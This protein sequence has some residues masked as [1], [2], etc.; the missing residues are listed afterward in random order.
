MNQKPSLYKEMNQPS[1]FNNMSNFLK[2]FN[3]FRSTFTGDPKAQVQQLI[4]SGQL[5]QEQF[6]QFA[7]VANQ[8]KNFIR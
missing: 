1:P 5:S 4:N 7:E 8:I 6:N 2:A 3:N